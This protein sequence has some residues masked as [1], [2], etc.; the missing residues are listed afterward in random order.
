MILFGIILLSTALR[1]YQFPHVIQWQDTGMELLRAFH[2]AQYQEYSVFGVP[3]LSLNFYHPPWYLYV[4]GMGAKLIP[5]IP[6]LLGISVF[7]H[8][9]SILPFY[10]ITQTWLG[11]SVGL[12]ASF[13]YAIHPFMIDVSHSLQSQN[14]IV[15]LFLWTFALWIYSR[16]HSSFALE[17][18]TPGFMTFAVSVNYAA[19]IFVGLIFLW[20]LY[21]KRKNGKEFLLS[22]AIWLGFCLLW[23]SPLFWYFGL[24]VVS[25]FMSAPMTILANPATKEIHHI[26]LFI[27]LLHITGAWILIYAWNH[28][29]AKWRKFMLLLSVGILVSYWTTTLPHHLGL[30]DYDRTISC[31]TALA[32][33]LQKNP[34]AH[35][36]TRI[37][38]PKDKREYLLI[39]IEQILDKKLV[40]L[41]PSGD[42]FD[43]I[44]PSDKIYLLCIPSPHDTYAC[45][46]PLIAQQANFLHAGQIPTEDWLPCSIHEFTKN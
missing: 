27:P 36:G 4:L 12:L 38:E 39:L 29:H 28:W 2:S 33:I 34:D 22:L 19:G 11:K 31:S 14:I 21:E 8:A 6:A 41:K 35:I 18:I 20:E 23:L 1:F 25:V 46:D 24:H 9:T 15:P 17:L 5:S 45:T 16:K 44:T 32:Q 43:W 30:G 26:Y 10:F 40:Q 13:F 7:I 3:A 37:G 42:F